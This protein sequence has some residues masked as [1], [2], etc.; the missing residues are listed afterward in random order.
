MNDVCVYAEEEYLHSN[1]FFLLFPVAGYRHLQLEEKD[2]SVA[3]G[4]LLQHAG[5]LCLQRVCAVDNRGSLLEQ[6]QDLQTE[7]V[8]GGAGENAGVPAN[9]T[10]TAPAPRTGRRRHG[11]G[12]AALRGQPSGK[13]GT[14]Q[15]HQQKEEAVRVL[16][17]V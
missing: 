4:P 2:P 7:A 11:D 15:H 13:Q 8:R 12:S 9:A 3:T 1:P 5:R 17:Q 10:E 6:E 14:G 16:H